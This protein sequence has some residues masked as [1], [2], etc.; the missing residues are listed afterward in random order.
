[1]NGG[2]QDRTAEIVLGY[3][4]RS[5]A[6]HLLENP[7]N[8]RKGY[9]IRHGVLH[10][11]GDFILFTDADLSSPIEEAPKLLDALAAGADIAIGSRWVRGELQTRHQSIARQV[12]GRVF[13]GLLRV[14]LRLDFSAVLKP[15]GAT[16]PGLCFPCNRSKAG[17]SIPRSC[18][19]QR[20]WDS[21]CKRCPWFGSTT[22]APASTLLPMAR[23]WW[24][25]SC[26][27][28]AIPR[29]ESTANF[30][31]YPHP[32]TAKPGTPDSHGGL[33]GSGLH[34][35]DSNIPVQVWQRRDEHVAANTI[36]AAAITFATFDTGFFIW[37]SPIASCFDAFP[38]RNVGLSNSSPGNF[39]EDLQTLLG[40]GSPGTLFLSC[41]A[42]SVSPLLSPTHNLPAALVPKTLNKTLNIVPACAQLC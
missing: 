1:V 35:A 25:I 6:V 32:N 22:T 2:S 17:A 42:T 23:A 36:P 11:N 38:R 14:L 39:V 26:A 3:A 15:S 33:R 19:S 20:E 27:S 30:A 29:P 4:Q 18:F 40:P 8:C 9:S 12:L 41:G 21:K 28:A 31:S 34:R 7:R 16:R 10:A 37:G 13:N 24:Q 5:P